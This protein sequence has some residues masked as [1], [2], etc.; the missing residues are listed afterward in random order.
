MLHSKC[1]EFCSYCIFSCKRFA[2]IYKEIYE[3]LCHKGWLGME[4]NPTTRGNFSPYK[5]AL[6][7]NCNKENPSYRTSPTGN[8]VC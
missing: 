5:Q 7:V 4:S 1:R 3:K 2:A 8:Y 6:T